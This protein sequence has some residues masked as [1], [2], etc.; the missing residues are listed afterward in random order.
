MHL[1]C[2]QCLLTEAQVLQVLHFYFFPSLKFKSK[3]HYLGVGEITESDHPEW[4]HLEGD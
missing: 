1:L 2:N 4:F 3:L